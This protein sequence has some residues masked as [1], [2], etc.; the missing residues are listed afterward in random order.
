MTVDS[1]HKIIIISKII[2][3]KMNTGSRT[4]T[5]GLEL[6]QKIQVRNQKILLL[7]DSSKKNPKQYLNQNPKQSPW[8]QKKLKK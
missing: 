7:L 5:N 6:S 4:L 3:S 1:R 2:S 8:I